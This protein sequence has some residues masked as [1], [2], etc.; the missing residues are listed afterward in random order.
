MFQNNPTM[1]YVNRLTNC[2]ECGC[3]VKPTGNS[4]IARS[5]RPAFDC[6][7]AP[8]AWFIEYACQSCRQEGWCEAGVL[9]DFSIAAV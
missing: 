6:H 8:P 9:E 5:S 3:N 7:V 4:K 1:S 2:V